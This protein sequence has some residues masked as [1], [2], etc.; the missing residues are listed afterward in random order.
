M[1]DSI[2]LQSTHPSASK[3]NVVETVLECYYSGK[4]SSG[5]LFQSLIATDGM[6]M[7]C[8]VSVNVIQRLLFL[9]A[10]E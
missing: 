2:G 9:E 4:D 5:Q 10:V 1:C 8:H 7:L 6:A 3:R